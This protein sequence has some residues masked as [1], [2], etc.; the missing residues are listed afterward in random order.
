M[1]APL[2]RLCPA[3]DV[4]PPTHRRHRLSPLAPPPAPPVPTRSAA[5]A[6]AR[7]SSPA[8]FE[9]NFALV[10]ELLISICRRTVGNKRLHCERRVLG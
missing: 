5:S 2:F 3:P 10:F 8:T 7:A 6:A 9:T 1:R 4:S